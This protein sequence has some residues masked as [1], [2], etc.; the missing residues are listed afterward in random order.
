MNQ[1]SFYNIQRTLVVPVINKHFSDNIAQAREESRGKDEAILGDGRFDS[2]G[3]CAKYCTYT[4]IS[5]STKKIIAS[6]TIQTI[7]GKG[8]APLELAAFK[9]CLDDLSNDNYQVSVVA[10][11]RNRQLAKW[12]RTEI[13]TIKHKYDPWHF[14]KNIKSK[15][16]PLTQ[17]KGCKILQEWLKPIGN[18]LFWCSENC[19]GDPEKLIQMW[20]SLL[21]HV[22]DKH[23]FGKTYP[24][25]KRCSHKVYTRIAARKKKWL[26]KDSPA[27]NNL[28]KVVLD[29]RNLKDMEQLTN[30][31]H[32]GS[33]E[34]FH[35]LI[36]CYAPK[37]LGFELNVQDARVKLAII[38]HNNNV[39]KEQARI[40]KVKHGSGKEG[41]LRFK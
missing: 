34:V 22:V 12:L 1:T 41:E 3:K 30:P 7:K 28:E 13:P 33:L 11:D 16:R 23:K 6:T 24:K 17:R 18:H 9:I 36:N 10:T 8:S 26:T 39:G 2:P 5:P 37:R 14:V 19:G 40:R 21:H 35:S 20:K 25:Y 4:C 32:T 15:L 38:D 29:K 27:Y 31:L